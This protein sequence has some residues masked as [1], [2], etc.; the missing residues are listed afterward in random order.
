MTI[1]SD[2][3]P[4]VPAPV[5]IDASLPVSDKMESQKNLQDPISV[6]AQQ[7]LSVVKESDK[8]FKASSSSSSNDDDVFFTG[9][10]SSS[11]VSDDE[12]ELE[13]TYTEPVII[14]SDVDP[15]RP[16][17]Q[18]IKDQLGDANILRMT[19]S[20]D[21]AL[22]E[23]VQT[24]KIPQI[25]FDTYVNSSTGRTDY[26]FP[27]EFTVQA[28]NENG[29]PIQLTLERQF[30]VSASNEKDALV[31]LHGALKAIQN[32]VKSNDE[33]KMNT[34]RFDV[35]L[36]R[37]LQ[38]E[39]TGLK[40]VRANDKIAYQPDETSK[41]I[42]ELRDDKIFHKIRDKDKEK[43]VQGSRLSKQQRLL[44]HVTLVRERAIEESITDPESLVSNNQA[45]IHSNHEKFQKI[46][47]NLEKLPI[48]SWMA[49][50]KRSEKE[51]RFH[52]DAKKHM[53]TEQQFEAAIK[54]APLGL[55]NVLH[56]E[57]LQAKIGIKNKE[58]EEH[59]K[60]IEDL[61]K[62]R[63]T[64]TAD[65]TLSGVSDHIK[66]EMKK[67]EEGMREKFDAPLDATSLT[68]LNNLWIDEMKQEEAAL[69]KM[70]IDLQLLADAKKNYENEVKDYYQ[71]RGELAALHNDSLALN[72]QLKELNT[73]LQKGTTFSDLHAIP[74][75]DKI[76][77]GAK[78]IADGLSEE[79]AFLKQ[80]ETP[81]KVVVG[82]TK[83]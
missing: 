16:P 26:R 49:D 72:E 47:T 44:H 41:K 56:E 15:T 38:G 40:A 39:T 29:D 67:I 51:E 9:S 52:A 77:E 23:E 22:R 63:E 80:F 42:Y 73:G 71:Q 37:N 12:V 74:A 2:T 45:A 30:Y 10:S 82:L 5:S 8:A 13:A 3:S 46:K 28:T 20:I 43:D 53:L 79:M 76:Q 61:K 11:S 24:G 65:P 27:V 19:N 32:V 48:T 14:P 21:Q 68:L 60:G 54:E 57:H 64:I 75:K 66:A 25:P 6:L 7:Q 69:D 34:A 59:K 83:D 4:L 55:K 50:P 78:K 62:A 58:Y 17:Q 33:E 1:G 81:H 31:A 36:N 35:T 18:I 70:E